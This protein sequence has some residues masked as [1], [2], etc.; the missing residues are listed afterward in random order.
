MYNY[1]KMQKLKIFYIVEPE[2]SIGTVYDNKVWNNCHTL[3]PYERIKM[4]RH[5][6]TYKLYQNHYM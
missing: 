3:P 4:R 2:Q 6:C 1:K 5:I